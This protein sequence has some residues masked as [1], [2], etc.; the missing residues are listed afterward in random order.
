MPRSQ[1]PYAAAEKR[2]EAT[3][4]ALWNVQNRYAESEGLWAY[5][6]KTCFSAAC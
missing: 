6:A 2:A 1:E 5:L 4:E 3:S